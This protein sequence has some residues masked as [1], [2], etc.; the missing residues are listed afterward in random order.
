MWP[1]D[2]QSSARRQRIL[3]HCS[4]KAPVETGSRQ[5]VWPPM[6]QPEPEPEAEPE[7]EPEPQPQP[8]PQ[9]E[10]QPEPQPEPTSYDI[11][12]SA[13]IPAAICTAVERGDT[14]T[15]RQLLR[16]RQTVKEAL[17]GGHLG[18]AVRDMGGT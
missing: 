10:L 8:Q 13:S 5:L 9:P 6:P 14:T 12:W 16:R 11:A 17:R 1:P 2:E 18:W 15:L 7:P 3:E 4:S